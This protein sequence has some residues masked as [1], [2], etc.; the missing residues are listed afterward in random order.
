MKD[1]KLTDV[2][3][4]PFLQSNNSSL[5][6]GALLAHQGIA[7]IPNFVVD[8]EIALGKLMPVLTGYSTHEL[9]FYS[10]RPAEHM[11]SMRLKLF[12]DFLFNELR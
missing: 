7:L 11:L 3:I 6:T 9:N 1:N 2:Y 10:L 8:D 12:N 4:N 5:F